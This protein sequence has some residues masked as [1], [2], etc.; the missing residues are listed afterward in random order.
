MEAVVQGRNKAASQQP[1]G[2]QRSPRRCRSGTITRLDQ[3]DFQPSG[4]LGAC[5]PFL[6]SSS[7]FFSPSSLLLLLRPGT[8]AHHQR[9]QG[10]RS[11]LRRAEVTVLAY[12]AHVEL[13]ASLAGMTAVH[14]RWQIGDSRN[15]NASRSPG[16]LLS[17]HETA[18]ESRYPRRWKAE[19]PDRPS[20]ARA[21][22]RSGKFLICGSSSQHVRLNCGSPPRAIA[23]SMLTRTTPVR[24]TSL[25]KP[26]RTP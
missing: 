2:P 4:H 5:A 13:S 19:P 24:V 15:L 22:A 11:G 14:R 26:G 16:F 9:R 12:Q 25:A 8:P 18:W 20:R 10:T 23:T 6:L 3:V 21:G 7:F 17:T 1:A